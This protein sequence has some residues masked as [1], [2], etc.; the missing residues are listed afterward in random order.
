MIRLIPAQSCISPKTQRPPPAAASPCKSPTF[1]TWQ[2]WRAATRDEKPFPTISATRGKKR[3]KHDPKPSSW[4]S[5]YP[6]IPQRCFSYNNQQA[7][8]QQKNVGFLH[9]F[10]PIG[11][12]RRH[13]WTPTRCGPT[14]TPLRWN[15]TDSQGTRCSARVTSVASSSAKKN[16]PFRIGVGERW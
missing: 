3:I 5:N 2:I 10:F 14:E 12:F 16:I 7:F 1:K 8:C 6:K 11:S 4:S 15:E 13:L 9:W